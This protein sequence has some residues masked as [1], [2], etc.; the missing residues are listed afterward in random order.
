MVSIGQQWDIA[1]LILPIPIPNAIG[2]IGI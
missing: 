2:S 1:M